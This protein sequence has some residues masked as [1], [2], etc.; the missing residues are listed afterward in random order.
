MMPLTAEI[1]T[2]RVDDI[3][4]LLA[5]LQ[6]MEVTRLLDEHF[7]THG[8]WQGLS[9]GWTATIW[10]MHILSQA[11]HRLNRVQDWVDKH[12][13]TLRRCTGQ[14]IEALDFSDDRLGAV[15]RYLNE[16]EAW[17]RYEQSQGQCLLRV[18]DLPSATVRLDTTTASTYQGE[19]LE[20]LFRRGVSKDHRPELAQVKAM[21]ATLDPLGL[22]L[23]TTVVDGSRADDPLYEPA[24]EQVRATLNRS[25]VLYIGDSKMGAQQ[26]RAALAAN[27][28]YYLVP[29]SATQLPESEL[30]T[31]LQPVWEGDQELIAVERTAANGKTV[32]VAKGYESSTTL[33]VDY[34]DQA[35]EWV[36]RRLIVRSLSYAEAQEVA[37]RR[38]LENAQAALEALPLPR[39]G[40]KRL[41]SLAEYAQAIEEILR[42]YRVQGL[43][44]CTV[45]RNAHRA[46][47]AALWR[48]ACA[49]RA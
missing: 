17:V 38:R 8:N 1:V 6:Q 42:R 29:L 11:D 24:I 9:L 43:P 28:D 3:P 44:R 14:V 26:T 20:G 40:K 18:Y 5:H 13:E 12:G 48:S 46:P 25:G 30:E 47:R 49:P 19:D 21:L 7:P 31:Y 32:E 45:Y 15:L 37:L 35:L 41:T 2:E 4:V 27:E 39:R 23:A 36:E 33:M 34:D 16:D 22:P 10:L